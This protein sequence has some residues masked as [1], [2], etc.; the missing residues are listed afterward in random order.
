M[1]K[2]NVYGEYG[3]SSRWVVYLSFLILLYFASKIL[4]YAL[5]N[6]LFVENG[7]EDRSK[8]FD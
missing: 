3:E 2:S 8:K 5:Q 1:G 4:L 7:P 6:D